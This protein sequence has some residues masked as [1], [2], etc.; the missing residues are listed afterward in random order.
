MTW[1]EEDG[2][3]L[4]RAAE[5]PSLGAHGE[6]LEAALLEIKTLVGYVIEDLEQSGETVPEPFSTRHFSG[7]FNVR[8]ASDLHRALAL[9]AARE[10]VSLNRLVTQKLAAGRV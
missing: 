3:Y 4:G 1:S 8:I 7:R 9:E 2:V 5:F 10:G 6:T